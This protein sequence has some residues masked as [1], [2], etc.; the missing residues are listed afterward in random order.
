[1]ATPVLVDQNFEIF[2]DSGAGDGPD[3]EDMTDDSGY[4]C[5]MVMLARSQRGGS[6]TSSSDTVT[7]ERTQIKR[8]QSSQ[9]F[10]LL[11]PKNFNSAA[12][13]QLDRRDSQWHV[14]VCMG[15][16]NEGQA[17]YVNEH[18]GTNVRGIVSKAARADV[19]SSHIGVPG[20][21]DFKRIF[22]QDFYRHAKVVP[23]DQNV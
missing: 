18:W 4:V 9:V 22:G 1:M 11:V 19:I 13:T 3:D 16:M 20:Y 23:F 5:Y 12:T 7:T 8:L 14:V 10:T 17:T 21:A 6:K 15:P 2:E